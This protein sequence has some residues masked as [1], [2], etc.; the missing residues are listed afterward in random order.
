MPTFD[1]SVEK[2]PREQLRALQFQKLQEVLRLVFG[3]NRF[4]TKKWRE[5]G[6]TSHDIQSL[7]D[8]RKLPFTCKS[9]LMQAQE[10]APPF[11]TNATFLENAYSRV[12]QTSGTTGT[13]LRVVDT[14]ESWEWWGRCWGQVLR[15]AGVTAEDRIFLPFAFGPFIGFWA[16][17]EGARQLGAMMIPGGGWDSVQRLH[18]MRD[19]RATVI[20]CTPTY[21]LRLAEV[22]REQLFDLRSIP[23]RA[24]IHAGE[25]GANV[26]RTKAR[27]EAAWEAKCF[28]HAGASEVGAHSFECE[29]QPG[30]IHII[31]S[32]FIIEVIDPQTGAELPPGETGELVITNLGRPGF[33][34]IRYRTGDLVQLN[35]APC[36][37]GR[38]Y[39][40][41]DGGLL[42][43]SDDMVTIRG[44]NVYPTA[45]ENVIR[46]FSA[47]D[48]FQV[49]VKTLQEMHHLEVQIEVISG[50][51]PENVRT[52]VEQAIYRSLSLRPTV[53]V[54]QPGAL[55]RFELKARRFR[56]LD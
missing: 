11:G 10:E 15:G 14:P 18:M 5:A 7:T 39:A 22:A 8:L 50:H 42:G 21:A 3:R 23:V 1:Q 6:L 26:A 25:P 32:E 54:A 4:Y 36:A 53:T 38:T 16:A 12:H 19:L 28:D 17:V 41:F 34:V 45:I 31:E 24:L 46:Q 2:L 52:D 29:L 48:E 44:V 27:I 13:P 9:E 40:R 47:V 49:T 43:R 33:P 30:G 56:R 37:C 35:L 55:A 20:C 51:N